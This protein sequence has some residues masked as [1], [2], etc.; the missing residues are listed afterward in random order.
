MKNDRTAAG[1]WLGEQVN[2]NDRD[3]MIVKIIEN[4]PSSESAAASDWPREDG[5]DDLR[6][7]TLGRFE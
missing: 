1:S 7:A 2:S 6:T 4:L 5:D 3:L